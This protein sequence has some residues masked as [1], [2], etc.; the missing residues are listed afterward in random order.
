MRI[1]TA[2]N[3][4]DRI[5]RQ[6][7]DL[8]SLATYGMTS[9]QIF[10][11][12]REIFHTVNHCPEWVRSYGRGWEAAK[13]IEVN[14]KLVFFYKMSNGKLFSTHKNREDYYEKNGLGPKEV[15]EKAV[16]SGHYWIVNGK[17]K[18]YF[19]MLMNEGKVLN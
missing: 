6:L 19:I 8:Y 15:Y 10:K 9:D 5:V 2:L 12:S 13:R 1:S 7:S 14:Q 18:P 4:R 3:H 16:S 17:P 11:R